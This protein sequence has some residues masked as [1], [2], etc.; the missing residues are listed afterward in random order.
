MPE[1]IQDISTIINKMAK[2]LENEKDYIFF[3]ITHSR[4]CGDTSKL[5]STYNKLFEIVKYRKLIDYTQI[6]SEDSIKAAN[7]IY[8]LTSEQIEQFRNL[9]INCR[10]EECLNFIDDTLQY[11]YK[12]GINN[13]N[14]QLLCTEIINCCI[15]SLTNLYH[16]LPLCFNVSIIYSQF[17]S[18]ATIDE[19]A[20]LCKQFVVQVI[21][22]INKNQKEGDYIID[23]ITDYIEKHYKE[24]I[25]LDLL[26]EKLN[27][28]NNY[29]SS[30]FKERTGTNLN[31]YINNFRIKKAMELLENSSLKITDISC[32]V[33]FSNDN[34]FR[35][36][37]KQH[38]GKTPNE[39][40]KNM[41]SI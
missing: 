18:F 9:L 8:Y 20:N 13:F 12:K 19:Y 35:R 11:N 3:T 21:D 25:Y 6:L 23:Y 4:V 36:I 31:F 10:N 14:I 37:F 27:L 7:N 29:I 16:K 22:Y 34:T 30:Y 5:Y 17:N 26:A 15:K 39:Y 38:I 2:K 28:T 33:G 41:I 40:R 24:D 1:D 32:K